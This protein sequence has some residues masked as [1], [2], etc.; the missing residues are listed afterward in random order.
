M[1]DYDVAK[2]IIMIDN[3][4]FERLASEYSCG[5]Q[6]NPRPPSTAT[7]RQMNL[8]LTHVLPLLLPFAQAKRPACRTASASGACSCTCTA[9]SLPS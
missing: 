6:S 5:K 1:I 3:T 4:Q 8:F 9:T 7:P 2:Q